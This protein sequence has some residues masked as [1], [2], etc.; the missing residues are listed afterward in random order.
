LVGKLDRHTRLR[1]RG[2][3][4]KW[5]LNRLNLYAL[6]SGGHDVD[7]LGLSFPDGHGESAADHVTQDLVEDV[8][9][10]GGVGSQILQQADGGGDASSG[11]ADAGL[12]AAGWVSLALYFTNR[13][14]ISKSI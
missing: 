8:F 6:I 7:L 3:D 1:K 13:L 5:E 10:V 11:A 4:R 9:Q 2:S 12:G 14:R